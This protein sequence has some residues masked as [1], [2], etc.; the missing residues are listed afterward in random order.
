MKKQI[1]I[2]KNEYKAITHVRNGKKN[3][4]PTYGLDVAYLRAIKRKKKDDEDLKKKKPLQ[5]KTK[6]EDLKKKKPI[7]RKAQ[8]GGSSLLIDAPNSPLEKEADV[9]AE[10]IVQR[11]SAS[12]DEKPAPLT[13]SGISRSAAGSA[14]GS[15]YAPAH[16]ASALETTKGQGQP[17]PNPLRT[18]MEG[19]IGSDL[20]GV[21]I[22][23]DSKAVELS[24]AVN[25]QA[26]TYGQDVYFNA[27]KYQP[28]S[29]EGLML[30]GHEVGHAG[31]Q[32]INSIQFKNSNNWQKKISLFTNNNKAKRK[33]HETRKN[34]VLIVGRPSK[35]LP[36]RETEKEKEEMTYWQLA[37][38]NLSD[39]VFEGLTVDKALSS[40]KN[41]QVKI[42]K[43]YIIAHASSS[44][45][46]EVSDEDDIRVATIDN[47]TTQIKLAI[48][49]WGDRKPLSIEMLSCY[50]GGEPKTMAKIGE[51]F[52]AKV[53]RA[54]MQETV[55]SAAPIFVNGKKMTA[56][57]AKSYSDSKLN[58]IIEKSNILTTYDYIPGVPHDKT[59][60]RV[61]KLNEI[62]KILRKLG[63]VPYISFN[64][65]PHEVGATPYWKAEIVQKHETD[66]ISDLE[67]SLFR[68]LIEVQ[69]NKAEEEK[70]DG[71]NIMRRANINIANHSKK[72]IQRTSP[73]T[74]S[75]MPEIPKLDLVEIKPAGRVSVGFIQMQSS[76]YTSQKA[77][78][79]ASK[80]GGYA[81][82]VTYSKKTRNLR[83]TVREI[84]G[85]GQFGKVIWVGN[86]G[87]LPVQTI[88]NLNTQ[89]NGNAQIFGWLVE[90]EIANIVSDVTGQPRFDPMKPG[91]GHGMDWAPIQLEL[92]YTGKPSLKPMI[93]PQ[94]TGIKSQ[95]VASPNVQQLELPGILS[96]SIP[97]TPTPSEVLKSEAAQKKPSYKPVEIP[98]RTI[99]K[100][101]LVKGGIQLATPILNILAGW[102]LADFQKKKQEENLKKEIENLNLKVDE[103]LNN[104]KFQEG[105]A[106][107]QKMNSK[108]RI[109]AFITIRV[110]TMK[111]LL[112]DW[113]PWYTLMRIVPSTVELPFKEEHHKPIEAPA[114]FLNIVDI[115]FSVPLKM[116]K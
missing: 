33:G 60:N 19:V 29:M 55:I 10:Q 7:L 81:G 64:E 65:S 28:G 79:S 48:T 23:T 22:H 59:L 41:L 113:G 24:E 47:L 31:Q 98:P 87:Q 85:P 17:L 103:Y 95:P 91:Y 62:R 44:G 97:K 35:T 110:E 92:P 27:G 100:T 43:L 111:N 9:I 26:F 77:I 106:I 83:L 38:Y 74:T 1:N 96:E 78:G 68:G 4:P 18:D 80:G 32:N 51:A 42:N 3:Q 45:I 34:V 67:S 20:S 115:S 75:V 16:V 49:D 104:A 99:Q 12:A 71:K 6:E 76:V 112:G 53:I 50:G 25:A 36:S 70:N 39:I 56:A 116:S 57:L 114:T 11:M 2:P 13:T 21:R 72:L 61:E 82:V 15:L 84:L 86:I 107:I 58:V 90:S 63:A 30:L 69:I 37:A 14:A 89:S 102:Y 5:R 108:V 93:T 109:F 101:I 40:L 94:D 46:G 73:T 105:I 54:P 66:T 52:G 8:P 88:Q